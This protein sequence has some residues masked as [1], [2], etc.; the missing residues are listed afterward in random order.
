MNLSQSQLIAKIRRDLTAARIS[1]YETGT[2]I[3]SLLTLL[4]YSRAA[5]IPLEYLVDDDLD[6]DELSISLALN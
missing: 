5:R 3:P 6:L 1:E 2:R 4:A